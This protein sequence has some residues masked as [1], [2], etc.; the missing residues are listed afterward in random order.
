[1]DI[2]RATAAVTAKQGAREREPTRERIKRQAEDQRASAVGW[3]NP[4]DDEHLPP[5]PERGLLRA[6]ASVSE[7]LPAHPDRPA[8]PATIHAIG[9]TTPAAKPHLIERIER[10]A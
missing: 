7:E 1:M 10:K 4:Q 3:F 8:R 6:A 5:A 2:T 9:V